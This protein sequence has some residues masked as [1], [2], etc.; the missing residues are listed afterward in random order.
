MAVQDTVSLHALKRNIPGI[1]LQQF[2]KRHFSV[3]GGVGLRKARSNFVESSAAYAIVCY[4]LQIKD[5]HNGQLILP[6]NDTVA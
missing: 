2:F 4:L 6:R 3:K 1:T 5:R